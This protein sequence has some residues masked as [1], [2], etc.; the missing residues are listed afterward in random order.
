MQDVERIKQRK[1]KSKPKDSTYQKTCDELF[2]RQFR[3]QPCE[4]CASMRKLVTDGVCG[5]HVVPKSR[6]KYLRYD[7]RN[8]VKVCQ[9][10]HRFGRDICAHGTAGISQHAFIDW[11]IEVRPSDYAFLEEN[12]HAGCRD[13]YKDML[14]ILRMNGEVRR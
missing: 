10:H 9:R 7:K 2:M 11:F 6:S 8:I 1:Q 14:D 13:K 3:C 5:H 12:K 4:V